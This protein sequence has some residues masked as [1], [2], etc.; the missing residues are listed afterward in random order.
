MAA[1]NDPK[2]ESRTASGK[3]TKGSS[4][5]NR[6][7]WLQI[8]L[9]TEF[10]ITGVTLM[11]KSGI[12]KCI[13]GILIHQLNIRFLLTITITH[14]FVI[15]HYNYTFVFYSTNTHFFVIDQN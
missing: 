7:P 14:S 3:A 11:S 8:D 9:R 6:Y 12:F 5:S 2:T 1:D 13:L 15:D 10:V 4:K